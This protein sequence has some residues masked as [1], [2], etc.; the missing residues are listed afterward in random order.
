[1][2]KTAFL[3]LIIL[4]S[5]LILLAQ[6]NLIKPQN[7]Y[8][9]EKGI[10][11]WDGSNVEIYGFGVNYT[12][13]FAHAYR[14]AKKLGIDPKEAIMNDVY[15]FNRLGFDLYRVHVWDTEISDSLGNL[16]QNE[17]LDTFDFLINE[18]KKNDI[19]YVL[20]PIAFWGNGWPEPDEKT[21]GFSHKYG[22]GNCL[23]NPEAIKAQQNY[24]EQ[25]MNHKNP[26][27]GIS[28]KEDPSL[29]AMEISNE[30]HH[31]G[32]G[33]VVT[34]F[35]K[36]MVDAIRKTE[37]SKPIF[38]NVSHAVQFMEDYFKAGIQGG[39]FQWYPTGLGYQQEL[40]G[41]FLPNVDDYHIP[42][43]PVIKK[44]GGAKYVYE[45]DA[46]DINKSYIYPAMARSFREAGI[47][48]ATHFAYD[49]TF[50]AYAN[51]EYNTHYM[52]LS[53]T[54]QKAL[55]LMIA[56]EVFH[57]LPLGVDQGVYP[58]NKTFGDFKVSYEEDLAEYNTDKTLIYTSTTTSTPNEEKKLNKIAGFGSS[59]VVKYTGKGAY[60]LDKISN[61]VWRLEVMPDAIQVDNP[62]GRNSLKK[63]V[64]VIKWAEHTLT[65]KLT[66]LG[67]EFT[68]T[69]INKNNNFTPEISKNKFSIKPGVYMLTKSSVKKK[70]SP[71]DKFKTH[72]LMSFYAPE[73]TV[74]KTWLKHTP[75]L[76]ASENIGSTIKV[77]CVSDKEISEIHVFA[78][79]P[80]GWFDFAL[81]EVEPYIFSGMIPAK[82]MVPGY[83]NYQL[84]V[85][86][87]DG[88][89]RTYP[90]DKVGKPFDW[91]FYD[92][93][94]YKLR[95]VNKDL[96]ITLFEASKD[97]NLVVKPW[98]NTLSLVPG[99]EV[100][101]DEYQIRLDKI[102][103]LDNEN[104][105]A[106]PIYDYTLDHFVF[107][108]I[109]GRKSELSSR[110]T[111]V[112]KGRG[113]D[114]KNQKVQIA[115]VMKDGSSYGTI[116]EFA[117]KI[118]EYRIKLDQLHPV[119]TVT[120]PRP[121][122]SFLPYYFQ[123]KNNSSFNLNNL[124]RIQISIGPGL[125]EN[126]LEEKQGVGLVR[127]W[128]IDN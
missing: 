13:P 23:T 92:R 79:N 127:V 21:P 72:Q 102:F 125:E 94:P 38:Y 90:A 55:S 68:V 33:E 51:T 89:S 32:E 83:L 14:S 40:P 41:N 85:R 121:Y 27:T 122:P 56:G 36:S 18:L 63:T 70:W 37:T 28:Y 24:L 98:R 111:L 73:S 106:K 81:S 9:D 66:D 82:R 100:D 119:K 86:F 48:L 101:E 64:T 12:V 35:V 22:K 75:L 49:P 46:A 19:N 115:L 105:N 47:Q 42:F 50:L 113:L 112:V 67:N 3:S 117:P 11:R 71:S 93:T 39:T 58:E 20:T 78:N 124:E 61:G 126:E 44:Y 74:N 110:S 103:E 31:R 4:S 95:V 60:F 76:E 80:S 7:S 25:F 34:A 114:G 118:R 53:Y 16:L 120:E 26:Y 69:A 6:K 8:K 15:H 2:K 84:E 108:N 88:S 54:P 109:E 30:P 45:F 97:A 107:E 116:I 29:I 104:L 17:H 123:H 5:S 43:D 57:H 87:A 10:L 59:S 1:M 77:Q 96:P 128:L 91:D 99:S 62:Y 52:N 65:V